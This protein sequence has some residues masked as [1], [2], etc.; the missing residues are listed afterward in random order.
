MCFAASGL[1]NAIRVDDWKV[2]FAIERGPI[3]EAYRD[4]PA[5][6]V[7]TNLRADP[8]RPVIT[9]VVSNCLNCGTLQHGF[10]RVKCPGCQHEYLL[11]FSCRGR[12]FC[13]SCHNK[14]VVQ[15]SSRMKENVLF[16][17]PH[18]QYIFSIPKILRRFF[19]YDRKLI[20]KLSQ[21]ANKSLTIFLCLTLNRRDGIPGLVLA[22]QTLAIMRAGT[23]I[24]MYLQLTVCSVNGGIFR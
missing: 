5:W 17:V 9:G 12:W 7:I 22:I 15:F 14:K 21:C 19:L 4:T 16:P 11:A 6:P 2:A 1:L 24:C 8:F 3:N 13:P 18:R 23:R 20:G 10:A